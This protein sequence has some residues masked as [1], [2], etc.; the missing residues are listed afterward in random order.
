M[1]GGKTKGINAQAGTLTIEQVQPEQ[2]YEAVDKIIAIYVEYGKKRENLFKFVKR[3]GVE[4]LKSRV[5]NDSFDGD[6]LK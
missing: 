3:Y 5:I 4:N 1:I 6:S 2:L